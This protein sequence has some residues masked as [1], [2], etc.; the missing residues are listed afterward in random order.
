M[1]RFQLLCAA[2]LHG[3]VA[4]LRGPDGLWHAGFLQRVRLRADGSLSLRFTDH[5]TIYVPKEMLR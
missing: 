5:T 1:T 3:S 2:L 4:C